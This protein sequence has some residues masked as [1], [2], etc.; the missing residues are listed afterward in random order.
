TSSVSMTINGPA[1]IILAM[2]MNTAIDQNVEKYLKQ[3]PARWAA[4]EKKIAAMFPHGRP[5]YSG[6][7]PK[8]NE[9]LGLGLLG[10]TGDQ[11]VDAETYARI[12]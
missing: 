4:A 9:G 3:D 7:L 1:P 11:L 2:F 12:K 8:G 5:Q 10:V 6:E